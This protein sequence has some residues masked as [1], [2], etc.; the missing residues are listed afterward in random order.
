MST[1]AIYSIIICTLLLISVVQIVAPPQ[2]PRLRRARVSSLAPPQSS[3]RSKANKYWFQV[4]AWAESDSGYADRFNMP[5]TGASVEIRILYQKLTHTD[6]DLSYWVGINLPN[7]AFI[8]VGYDVTSSSG[9]SPNWFW[10][11]FPPGT[12]TEASV[13]FLGKVGRGSWS[14]GTWSKFSITASGKT[15]AAFVNGRQVGSYDFGVTNSGTNG[16]YASAEVAEVKESDNVLGPVEFR[17]LAYRDTSMQ[18]HNANSA[19]ALCCYSVGGDELPLGATYP[20]GVMGIPGD[21]NHWLAGSHLATLEDGTRLWPWYYLSVSSQYGGVS[22]AGWYVRGSM[23]SPLAA[24]I[25]LSQSERLH[26]NGWLVNGNSNHSSTFTVI[27]NMSLQASYTKQYFVS[28][29]TPVGK[30]FG[31]G[32]YDEGSRIRIWIAPTS[33]LERGFLGQLGVKNSMSRWEGDYTGTP[34]SDGSSSLIVDRPMTIMAVWSEDYG[35]MP[36]IVLAIVGV[37]AVVILLKRKGLPG[38]P[39]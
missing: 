24:D 21:D 26:L 17:N 14:N 11:Y 16:P 23:V 38:R 18:W 13:D 37:I 1:K 35:F 30:A 39:H 2:L 28:V 9:R 6:A 4:G 10:E 25:S 29:S 20:Y 34:A 33:I 15:W 31:S 19:V 22:G 7:D 32:W 36:E 5:I 3:T 12:A 8:Q 27:S